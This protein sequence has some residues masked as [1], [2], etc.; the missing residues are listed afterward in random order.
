MLV[1][2][3]NCCPEEKHLRMRMAVAYNSSASAVTQTFNGHCEASQS[4]HGAATI[5]ALWCHWGGTSMAIHRSGKTVTQCVTAMIKRQS[6]KR[7][8]ASPS[9]TFSWK[10]TNLIWIWVLGLKFDFLILKPVL[11]R[12]SSQ[13]QQLCVIIKS[14]QQGKNSC[15]LKVGGRY[16]AKSFMSNRGQFCLGSNISAL[17]SENLDQHRAESHFSS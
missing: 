6:E 16:F 17:A 9:T 4:H 8:H 13:M 14:I 5:G 12:S 11:V 15:D 7:H 2:V 1:C 3:K 10:G